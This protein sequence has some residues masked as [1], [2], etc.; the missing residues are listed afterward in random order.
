[1][2]EV[3]KRVSALRQWMRT[4]KVYA[5]IISGTDP[6]LSEYV[7]GHWALRQAYTNFSGSAGCV[8]ITLDEVRLFTDAR[9]FLQA[10]EELACEEAELFEA[11]RASFQSM[12]DYLGAKFQN[13]EKIAVDPAALSISMA[14]SLKKIIQGNNL[15]LLEDDEAIDF[16]YNR[17]PNLPQNPV[18]V[19]SA[20]L[21]G[22][23]AN[24]KL[25][26]LRDEMAQTRCDAHVIAT[27]DD[28]CWLLNMRGKDVDF[29]PVFISFLCVGI[30]S[31]QLF[32]DDLKLDVRAKEYLHHLDVDILD[33]NDFYSFLSKMNNKRVLI[34][35]SQV[36][37]KIAGI[38]SKGNKLVKA[39]NPSTVMKSKKNNIERRQLKSCHIDDALALIRATCSLEE[40]L[41]AGARIT[42]DE[43]ARLIISERS[44][45]PNYVGESFSA[46]VG[47]GSNGAIIHYRP[48][49]GSSPAIDL[50]SPL[51][52]DCGAQYTNGTTDITRS[53][54]FG[55][56]VP[57]LF[58]RN[59]T[60]VLKGH[61][62][63]AMAIFPEGTKGIQLDA[64]AR[65]ALWQEG[66][67]Y[68][69][70]TGHGVGFYLNVHE[71][72][73][74][75]GKATNPH[76]AGGIQKGMFISNEPGYYKNGEYGI[77]LEN[78]VMAVHSESPGFLKFE[79]I[80]LLPFE[81]NLI[82]NKLLN[83]IQV[84]WLEGYHAE[85]FEKLSPLLE[86]KELEWL[87]R[88][89]SVRFDD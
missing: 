20:E 77:R 30:E 34:S 42:E 44:K 14:N 73:E 82:S 39:I 32:I 66:L 57:L 40:K 56:K 21:I 19:Q 52:I 76:Y 22:K 35:D 64:L 24:E 69:H 27:L 71:G 72:P 4:N 85:V 86:T 78:L 80:S 25:S 65:K 45:S 8:L 61:I 26:A 1:M 63:L 54:F 29:N 17:R 58:K 81:P 49:E 36:N 37:Q 31:T 53:Y 55:K 51:L 48:K 7:P 46:I 13:S 50:D 47:S 2:S 84:A 79:T 60:L 89:C 23:E 33:Y 3:S 6:H 87:R 59:Y 75:I 74:S 41:K 5:Y 11:E 67:D 88:R 38:L 68:G 16:S 18:E 15:E 10:K 9:Y 62:D 83:P 70:G 28:I 12:L 43:H